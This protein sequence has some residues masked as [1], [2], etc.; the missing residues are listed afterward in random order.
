MAKRPSS[1]GC[2]SD[3]IGSLSFTFQGTAKAG[4]NFLGKIFVERFRFIFSFLRRKNNDLFQF[5]NSKFIYSL[6]PDTVK[7]FFAWRLPFDV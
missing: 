3:L 6:L 4:S 1:R 7:F 2:A 5:Y